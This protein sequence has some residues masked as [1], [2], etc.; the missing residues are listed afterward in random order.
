VARSD[1]ETLDLYSTGE[2]TGHETDA[3]NRLLILVSGQQRSR[4]PVDQGQVLAFTP[5]HRRKL[6]D[7]GGRLPT[8]FHQGGGHVIEDQADSIGL[9]PIQEDIH[10]S[11][12]LNLITRT[13]I[14]GGR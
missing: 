7:G 2:R 9:M 14:T 6:A 12:C 13:L 8:A 5:K 11:H 1:I 10:Y 3:P 4:W